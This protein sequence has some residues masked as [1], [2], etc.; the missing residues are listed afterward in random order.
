MAMTRGNM[1]QVLMD[2]AVDMSLNMTAQM[3]GLPKETV[4]KIV[5]VGLPMLAKMADENPELL[6]AMYAQ[7][8]KLLPEPIQAFYTKLAENPQAQQALV[9]EFKTMVGPMTEALSRETAREAGTT[10]DQASKA[11][12]ATFPAVAQTLGKDTTEKTEAG[13]GQRLKDLKA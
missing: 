6:K 9:D 12:A 10:E 13:F 11:L 2:Q 3:L 4:T 5:Q 8:A 7:S 1:Q